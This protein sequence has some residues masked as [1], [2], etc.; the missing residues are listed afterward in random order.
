MINAA[1]K[2]SVS[3]DVVSRDIAGDTVLLDL[4]SGI[5]FGLDA[6][7]SFAWSL[8]ER[9]PRT[10]QELAMAVAGEFAVDMPRALA[11]LG[12]LVSGMQEKGL[13]LAD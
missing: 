6:V 11:D 13:L 10:L 9:A 8:L 12:E 1:A 3:P 5:Y 7:G 2:I 4:E